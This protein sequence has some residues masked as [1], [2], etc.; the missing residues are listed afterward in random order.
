MIELKKLNG[1]LVYVNPDLI[2]FIEA[3][4][5]I[6]LTFIDGERLMVLNDSREIIDKIIEFK[7]ICAVPQVKKD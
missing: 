3:T 5:D 2:R 1:K 7:R 6:V 4:P